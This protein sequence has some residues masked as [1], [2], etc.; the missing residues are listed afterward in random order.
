MTQ[1]ALDLQP[2]IT[3]DH[4]PESSI[5]DRFDAFHDANP[6]VANAL[7]ALA[8]Q[9]LANHPRVGMKALFERLRWESG[10]QTRGD[11][12]RLNNSFTA[13][14]GRLLI[15]RRPEWADAINTRELRAAA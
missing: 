14:Y 4:E 3:P 1:L 9:W 10:I 2:L 5:Q 15:Q 7:E 12:W 11:V 6:H 8:D 13:L